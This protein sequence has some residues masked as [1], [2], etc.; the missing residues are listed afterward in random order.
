MGTHR[1]AAFWRDEIEPAEQPE[2]GVDVESV[3]DVIEARR[4]AA[5][6]EIMGK[7]KKI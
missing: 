2:G 7:G 6:Q 3:G 5:D 1:R 4:A